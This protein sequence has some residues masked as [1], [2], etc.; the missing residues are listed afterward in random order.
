MII[1]A[2]VMGYD[3]VVVYLPPPARHHTIMHHMVDELKHP[4]PIN[5]EEGFIDSELGFVNR[6]QA[7]DIALHES[8]QIEKLN[9]PPYLYSEDL[10]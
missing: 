7:A 9:W 6:T 3:G 2:A 1:G 4:I 5:G 10:W 8:K